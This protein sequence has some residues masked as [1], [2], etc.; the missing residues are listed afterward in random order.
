MI[1]P[2]IETCQP[3][4]F[5]RLRPV[6]LDAIGGPRSRYDTAQSKIW[7]EHLPSSAEWKHRLAHQQVFA[8]SE[9]SRVCGFMTLESGGLIDLAFI[10][11]DYQGT[12]LFSRL[13]QAIEMHARAAKMARLTVNASLNAAGPFER[14]GF[15]K[16]ERGTMPLTGA[17]LERFYME[18]ILRG[19]NGV[20]EK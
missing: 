11:P 15:K 2:V 1:P 4:D 6:V 12:G 10:H 14:A 7:A 16:V 19:S 18:K 9:G 13:Y 8:A 20:N 17:S 5:E 3:S